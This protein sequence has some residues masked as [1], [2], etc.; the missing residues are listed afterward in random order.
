M[1][2]RTQVLLVV[3][4]LS[5]LTAAVVGAAPTVGAATAEPPTIALA[6]DGQ[7]TDTAG[8]LGDRTADVEAALDRLR[9]EEGV[10]LFVVFVE[11]FDGTPSQD[12][13]DQVARSNGLGLND[14]LLAVAVGDRQYAWSV[15]EGFPLTDA[16]LEAVA[17]GRI[18]TQLQDGDWGGAAIAAADGY[19]EE[20]A[21]T[22][23]A[24]G[25]GGEAGTDAGGR[26]G[27]L[28]ALVVA[29]LL[30][31]AAL[32]WF[33]GRRRRAP[34]GT[35]AAADP[36]DVMPIEELTTRA[37]AQLVELDDAL[38]SSAFDLDVATREFGEAAT[39]PFRDALAAASGQVAA[40]WGVLQQLNDG[41]ERDEPTRHALLK[42]IIGRC[43]SA[44]TTLDGQTERFEELRDRA[45][46][47]PELLAALRAE[48]EQGL[49]PPPRRGPHLGG[50]PGDLSRSGAGHRGHQP[51]PGPRAP[52][53]RGADGGLGPGRGGGR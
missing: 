19:R 25:G 52:G 11:S 21:G 47:A 49:G 39:A 24:T 14:A 5:V 38:K 3:A 45:G 35:G 1:L 41:T 36:L 44:D 23:T 13:A 10:Q 37:S 51:G 18:E 40:G 43:T 31:G 33:L 32:I 2:R 22:G 42:E 53:L 15:D 48:A 7:V 17:G 8:V 34:A 29:A 30:G 20:L 26:S 46:R 27:L 4:A 12:W 9:T 6:T 50:A 16:Q 28:I